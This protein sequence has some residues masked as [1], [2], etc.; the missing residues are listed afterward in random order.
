MSTWAN[1]LGYQAVWFAVVA[2][3]GRG[4]A[5]FGLAAAAIFVAGQL[6]LSVR[7]AL[8]LRLMAA[9]VGLGVLIDGLLAASGWIRYASPA[10]ALPPHGA[11][12]WILALWASFALT[13]PRSLIWLMR[14]PWLAVL[15][16]IL[17]APL[18]YAGAARGWGAAHFVA[19]EARALGGL[20]LGWGMALPLLAWLVRREQP[21]YS[22]RFT[23]RSPMPQARAP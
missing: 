21:A 3:A 13:L 7:R 5:V 11:P 8:D 15:F 6:A 23:E 19:P 14:R 17:G 10:P 1:F 16:G 12:L 20:A 4:C 18:A 22:G 9:A 2:S